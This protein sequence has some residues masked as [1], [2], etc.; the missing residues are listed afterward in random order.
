MQ[1][2]KTIKLPQAKKNFTKLKKKEN[3]YH[4]EA[5]NQFHGFF[6]YTCC[7]YTTTYSQV[8]NTFRLGRQ[9]QIDNAADNTFTSV[10]QT[11]AIHGREKKLEHGELNFH[12]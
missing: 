3:T 9:L 5:R 1:I 11:A 10:T 12:G 2:I 4:I 7:N 8:C 6:L